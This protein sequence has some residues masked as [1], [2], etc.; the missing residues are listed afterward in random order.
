MTKKCDMKLIFSVGTGRNQKI[1]LNRSFEKPEY[2]IC[3]TRNIIW[4]TF[5]SGC[6]CLCVCVRW[7]CKIY[8]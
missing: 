5:A 3:N 7:Q 1:E 6:V 8:F 4:E 2:L